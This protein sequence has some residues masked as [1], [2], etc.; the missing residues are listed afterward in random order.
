[1][2]TWVPEFQMRNLINIIIIEKCLCFRQKLKESLFYS[3]LQLSLVEPTTRRKLSRTSKN[4]LCVI[5]IITVISSG[6]LTPLA[7]I[8]KSYMWQRNEKNLNKLTY[9]LLVGQVL[10]SAFTVPTATHMA[11]VIIS[12]NLGTAPASLQFIFLLAEKEL[13]RGPA[14]SLCV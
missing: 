12:T 7:Y 2:I 9:C 14:S 1:M 3:Q 10:T 8:E 6:F 13:L 5:I 11:A 4:K